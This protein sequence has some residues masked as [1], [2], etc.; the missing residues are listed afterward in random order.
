VLFYVALQYGP[1][2]HPGGI[3]P[4]GHAGV[5]S[6]GCSCSS[7]LNKKVFVLRLAVMLNVMANRKT[8]NNIVKSKLALVAS[9]KSRSIQY[10]MSQMTMDAGTVGC[11]HD[12]LEKMPQNS[13]T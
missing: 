10:S 1:R 3:L 2:R 6:S 12:C 7:L 9:K 13:M 11:A 4:S 8:E 5:E